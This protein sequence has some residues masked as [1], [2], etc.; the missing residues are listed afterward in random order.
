MKQTITA[1][2][3]IALLLIGPA[4]AC[5]NLM[6]PDFNNPSIDELQENPTRAGV[7]PAATGLLVGARDNIAEF[8]GYISLTGILGRESYN[9]DGADTRYAT[10][11]YTGAV[12]NP[13]SPALGGNLWALRYKNIR[14][15]NI[16]LNAL[17]A[18]LDAPPEG[19]TP[20]EKEATRGFTKTIQ[21]LD[22]LLIINTRD[23]NGAPIDVDRP[24]TDPPAPIESK[25]EVFAHIVSLLEEART[26]LQAGG[27]EFPFPLSPGFAGFDRPAT[28]LEFNRALLARVEV[29]RMEFD[30]GAAAR[31]LAALNESFVSTAAPLDR[32]IYHVFSGGSG[33]LTNGLVDPDLFAHT[34]L[35][36]DAEQQP[37]G[38]LDA[39]FLR[40]VAEGESRTLLNLTSDLRFAPLYP[41]PFAP[42]SIIRNEEL[43]L[44]RAEANI[45]LG[46]VATAAQDINF[47]RVNSGGLAPRNDLTAANILD[48][49]LDQKR[50]SLVFEGGHRWIDMR[51]YGRLDELPLDRPGD[52]VHA[53]FEIPVDEELARQ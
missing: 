32:G 4:V 49:L 31:A 22:F 18:L 10:E 43:I 53:A 6:A 2:R 7:I 42:V 21:A 13:G 51:R 1:S 33:D 44:L 30:P 20:A 37:N 48:E 19:M 45:G 24:I 12:L 34:S 35:E 14:N 8:N 5:S 41:S 28:F 11:M 40:K 50:Y 15:A 39:R 36:A 29:Y 9:L 27:S 38:Q 25:E 23:V 47:V 16:V 26:H 17:N 52:V 46:N 3:L